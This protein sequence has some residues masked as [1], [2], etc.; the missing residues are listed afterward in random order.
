LVVGLGLIFLPSSRKWKRSVVE[1]PPKQPE[2]L[3][4]PPTPAQP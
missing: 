3:D 1:A 2:P 4:N